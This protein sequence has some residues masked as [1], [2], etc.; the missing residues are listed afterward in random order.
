MR[1]QPGSRRQ[2]ATS[3]TWPSKVFG[4]VELTL[5]IAALK[6]HSSALDIALMLEQDGQSRLQCPRVDRLGV[7]EDERPRPIQGL[8]HAGALTQ[9]QLAELV[10]D[11]DSLPC[12]LLAQVRNAQTNDLQ[13]GLQIGEV[14]EKVQTAS[15]ESFRQ[16]TS[17]VAS[18]N[19][20][21]LV[22]RL[23]RAEL[24][25]T[26]LEVAQDFR[27]EG[28]EF[29]IRTVDLINQEQAWFFGKD[30]FQQRPGKQKPLREEYI[31]LRGKFV[32]RFGEGVGLFEQ[33]AQLLPQELG[34]EH[35]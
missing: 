34:I 22:A 12:Q 4:N 7:Q 21:R 27:Q 25:H 10:N 19:D 35:L 6:D 17:V 3:E 30:R 33:G 1:Q 13:L 5:S 29:G 23:E 20:M 16:L 15:L 8:A 9:V 18:R 11:L 32:C 14:D 24:R 31:L 28:F 2:P 26:H